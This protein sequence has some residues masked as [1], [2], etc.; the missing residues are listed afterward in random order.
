MV[1]AD[2]L[3]DSLT[4]EEQ[5]ALLAG[6]DFWHTVAIERAGI[7]AMRVSDGPVGARG[8]RFGGGPSSIAVPCSTVSIVADMLLHV[9][10]R[11]GRAAASPN[12]C[13]TVAC[14]R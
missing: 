12:H 4:L 13:V 11:A 14:R 6:A 10:T 3:V 5:V 7:P 8:T 2:T 1:D 9:L